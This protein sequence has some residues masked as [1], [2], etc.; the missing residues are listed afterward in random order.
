MNVEAIKNQIT[1]KCLEAFQAEQPISVTELSNEIMDMPDNI[2]HNPSHHYLV[3]AVLLTA[4]H[5]AIGSSEEELAKDLR[6]AFKRSDIVP[7]A[8]CGTHGCCGAAVG[9]GIFFSL[10]TKN[11]PYSTDTW[12]QA[13]H[14]TAES[15]LAM[16]K[17]GGPRCCK[18][19]SYISLLKGVD[20]VQAEF[21]LNLKAEIPVCHY[22]QENK[23]CIH[24][25]CPYFPKNN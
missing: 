3:P 2:I 17:L 6:E 15:L 9:V 22:Y 7:G 4:Y 1:A 11:T 20:L 5:Q 23:E 19:C 21:D 8:V 18:R 25:K 24:Q 13:N 10:A 16:A 12:G 14:A